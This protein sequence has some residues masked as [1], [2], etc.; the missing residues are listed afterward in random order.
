MSAKQAINDKLQ[1]S[2]GT[3]LRCGGFVLLITKLRKFFAEY[4]SEIFLIGEYLSHA[5]CAPGTLLNDE[6]SVR[7]NHVLACNF[8]EYSPIIFF[9]LRLSN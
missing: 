3:H 1:G 9:I 2:V 4:V 7:D 6:K 8:A 5:L